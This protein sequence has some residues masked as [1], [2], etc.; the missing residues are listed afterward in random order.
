MACYTAM[1]INKQIAYD[2]DH[3]RQGTPEQKKLIQFVKGLCA[4]YREGMMVSN[5]INPIVGIFW[6]KAFDGLNELDEVNAVA[7]ELNESRA[8]E[9]AES[10]ANKYDELPD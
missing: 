2:M 10:I 8:E 9:D 4:T 6:Q 1:G 7:M 5:D 3:G